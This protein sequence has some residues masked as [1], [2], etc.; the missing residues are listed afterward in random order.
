[1]PVSNETPEKTTTEVSVNNITQGT[2][3]AQIPVNNTTETPKSPGFE[4]ILAVVG[5]LIIVGLQKK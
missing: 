3:T 1:V 4:A 2:L 5:F